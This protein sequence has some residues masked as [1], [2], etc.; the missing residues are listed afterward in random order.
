MYVD[1]LVRRRPAVKKELDHE[2]LRREEVDDDAGG[3]RTLGRE[4]VGLAAGT[5]V[6]RG[7]GHCGQLEVHQL[8]L[9]APSWDGLRALGCAGRPSI[10][11]QGQG[12]G[13][14]ETCPNERDQGRSKVELELDGVWIHICIIASDLP[15]SDVSVSPNRAGG[16]NS[17]V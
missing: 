6:T 5:L 12:A 8:D 17:Q 4:Y 2:L 15:S 10:H 7:P 9:V 14:S 16:N 11:R 3:L 1:E 13:R